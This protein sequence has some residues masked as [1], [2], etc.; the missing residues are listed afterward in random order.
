M[1]DIDSN[2]SDNE[3]WLSLENYN[4]FLPAVPDNIQSRLTLKPVPVNTLRFGEKEIYEKLI[5]NIRESKEEEIRNFKVKMLNVAR[6]EFNLKLTQVKEDFQKEIEELKEIHAN[7]R[8]LIR[9]KDNKITE[10]NQY[11][12]NQEAV[13]AQM[14]ISTRR[15]SRQLKRPQ[16]PPSSPE[17]LIEDE[18]ST[19]QIDSLKELCEAY[20]EELSRCRSSNEKLNEENLILRKNIKDLENR[21]KES[22][23]EIIAK[24]SKEKEELLNEYQAYR[25]QSEK[26]VE[27]R[28]ELNIRHTQTINLL[29]EELKLAKMVIQSPR[30]HKRALEKMKEL[31]MTRETKN[32]ENSIDG[33]RESRIFKESLKNQG[34]RNYSF[35][36]Y[37]VFDNEN[38]RKEFYPSR[39]FSRTGRFEVISQKSS[40]TGQFVE[41]RKRLSKNS[42]LYYKEGL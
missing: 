31:A 18:S 38:L 41:N 29:Q 14:R 24:L 23:G 7:S 35:K 20:K 12:A 1:S 19:I 21:I 15:L 11:V 5:S 16:L 34:V 10:L 22:T 9:K 8:T 25:L 26:E 4:N 30:V 33:K 32:D 37:K 28:E 6:K 3:F 17:K 27:A 39:S 36:E 13:I 40:R 2:D 42:I